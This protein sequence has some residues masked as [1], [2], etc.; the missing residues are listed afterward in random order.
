VGSRYN[1]GYSFRLDIINGDIPTK[2]GSA[3]ARDL[4]KVLDDSVEFSK[5]AVDKDITIRLDSEFVLHIFIHYY[6]VQ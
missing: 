2:D 6:D 3:V 5:Y 4:K 1:S